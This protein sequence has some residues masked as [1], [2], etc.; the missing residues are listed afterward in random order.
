MNARDM[1][2]RKAYAQ[3]LLVEAMTPEEREEY[4]ELQRLKKAAEEAT[5]K[6]E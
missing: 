6:G 1:A 3:R 5:E 2:N 4:E